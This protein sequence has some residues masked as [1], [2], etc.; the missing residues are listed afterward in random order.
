MKKEIS[1]L[2][3]IEVKPGQRDEQIKAYNKL[4][5]LVLAEQGCLEYDLRAVEENENKFVLVEKWISE[6][7][8]EFHDNTDYMKKADSLNHN[9]R[10]KPAEVIRLVD[11]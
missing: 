5:P 3:M 2:I 11:I 7:A 8:L 1:Q 10:A 9:F 4:V 6:G